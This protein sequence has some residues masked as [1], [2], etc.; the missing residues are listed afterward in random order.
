MPDEPNSCPCGG[1]AYALCCG[2]FIDGRQ[3]P[4]TAEALMRSRY[5]AH[6]RRDIRYLRETLAPDRRGDF[7]GLATNAFA[8]RDRWR[9]LRVLAVE[10]GGPDDD[11]G[12]VLFEARHV[13]DG[14]ERVHRELSLFRRIDGVWVYVEALA[15]PRRG[16]PRPH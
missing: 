11:V 12:R 8:A 3:R 15:E 16:R 2:R 1:G 7:D 4:A 13:S 9:G 14:V 10:R 5:T 6:V